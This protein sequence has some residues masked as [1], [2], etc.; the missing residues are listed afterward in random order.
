MQI[1]F[2]QTYLEDLFLKG[3]TTDKHHR[4]QP[5]V[6]RGYQK[7]INYL[8]L[9]NRPEDLYPFRSLHF[10]ALHGDKEG[11]FSVRANDQYR[12]E[13]KIV[14]LQDI[15]TVQVCHILDLTNHYE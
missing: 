12:V 13:L 14:S 5:Q 3:T 6:I 4:Y 2:E 7:A 9:A 10:E 8:K 1:L 11:L 15:I